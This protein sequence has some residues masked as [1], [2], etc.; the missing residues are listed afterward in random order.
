MNRSTPHTVSGQSPVELF[1]G[2]QIRNCSTLLKPNLNRAVEEKQVKQKEY[3]VE[4]RFKLREF[5]F[6]ELVL[7]HNWRGGLIEKW[8]PGRISQ[9][10]GPRNYL[11]RCGNQIR[12]V[13]AD[14]LKGTGGNPSW[15]SV[16]G[17]RKSSRV[18][19][20]VESEAAE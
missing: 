16:A 14:H 13:H 18:E 12:F 1:L 3:H 20:L 15:G 4:G 9:V 7:V 8:I 5:K 11:V 6:N 10:K 2:R 19:E 17:G